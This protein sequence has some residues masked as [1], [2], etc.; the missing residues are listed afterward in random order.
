M[1]PRMTK[2]AQTVPVADDAPLDQRILL[3]LVGY[4]C[5]RAYINIF[6]LFNKR[7]GKLELRPV[8]FSVLSILKSNPNINQ[9]R[10][11]AAINVSPPNMAI[12]LE[13]LEKRGL[14]VRARN[15]LDRRSHT[16][17]LSKEGT[18]LCTKAEKSVTELERKATAMLS[19]RERQQLLTI[20]Q[21]IFLRDEA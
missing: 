9:K 11:S 21:K 1:R 17:V 2:V 7:M 15:P 19:D 18:A 10:L 12:L 8:D 5:K 6:E 4:N 3:G 16:L 20:L 13:R 14:L